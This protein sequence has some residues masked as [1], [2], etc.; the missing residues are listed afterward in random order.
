MPERYEVRP[1]EASDTDA[2]ASFLAARQRTLRERFPLL[3]AR[4]ENPETCAEQVR[5]MLSYAT[6]LA[7][8]SESGELAGFMFAIQ[9]CLAFIR[10][11]PLRAI[12]V[13]R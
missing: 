1:F 9:T 10:C 6:G 11:C 3:P 13:A 4:F 7:A 2:A 8:T 5:S 12:R